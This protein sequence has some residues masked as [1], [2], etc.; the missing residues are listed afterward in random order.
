M[1]AKHALL[2]VAF[3]LVCGSSVSARMSAEEKAL[4]DKAMRVP[5][6]YEVD[7][8][9]ADYAWGCAQV[10]V[11]KYGQVVPVMNIQTISD[12]LIQTYNPVQVGSF[13]FQLSKTAVGEKYRIDVTCLYFAG[14]IFYAS[15]ESKAA[16]RHAHMLSYLLQENLKSYRAQQ[17]GTG[18]NKTAPAA[19]VPPGSAE[20]QSKASTPS[21]SEQWDLLATVEGKSDLKSDT[22]TVSN[23]WKVAWITQGGQD[24]KCSTEITL[25][26]P[27]GGAGERI[28]TIAGKDENQSFQYKAGTYYLDIKATQ[29]FK[30]TVLNKKSAAPLPSVPEVAQDKAP[31]K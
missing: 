9:E 18:D 30:I 24:P 23:E 15:G 12:Y 1:Q 5:S 22:F 6:S 17:K 27:N 10:I 21:D 16:E 29:Q 28:T 26:S 2:V 20:K 7:K 19:A 13:G 11:A 4:W 8:S 25:C 3:C 31:A 14:N